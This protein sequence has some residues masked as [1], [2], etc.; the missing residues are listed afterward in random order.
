MPEIL[1]LDNQL[2]RPL[3]HEL[4]RTHALVAA[5]FEGCATARLFVDDAVQPRAGVIVCNS[6]VLCAGDT[7][8]TGFLEEME[9]RFTNELIPA[10]I[11]RGNDAYLVYA[12]GD[13]WDAAVQYIFPTR[14]LYHG[15]RQY[16]EIRD[17]APKSDLQLPDAFS[18]Q[19]ITPEFMSSELEGLAAVRE[20][21]CSERASVEDFLA[22]SFGICPVYENG[23]AG[24]CMSEYNVGDRCEIGIATAPNYQRKGIATL[25]TW[26]FLT[27][28]HRRG[29][30]RVG[31]DCWTRNEPSGATARKAGF[32][33]VEEYPAIVVEL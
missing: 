18:M 28:A 19:L 11:A 25:A 29:Y 2:A 12:A 15:T 6:R 32:T 24:W 31:W 9:Q 10:H 4:E 13:G 27:E 3:F 5:F 30:T 14:D 16:Y 21:M 17:F 1:A 7:T 33:L 20:E 26:S 8:Q 23:I 22:R